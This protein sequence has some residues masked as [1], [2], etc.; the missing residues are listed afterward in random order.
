M[1]HQNTTDRALNGTSLDPTSKVLNVS[2]SGVTTNNNKVL[3]VLLYHHN[4]KAYGG[5]EVWFHALL[6][7]ALDVGE[8]TSSV[9]GRITHPLLHTG[10]KETEL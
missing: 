10:Q 8:W 6:P 4:M 3:S 7:S 5:T 2:N 9:Y 1:L